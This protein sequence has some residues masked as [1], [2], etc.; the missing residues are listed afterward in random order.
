VVVTTLVDAA[1]VTAA[2][3]AALYR[4]RWQVEVY[5]PQCP[6]SRRLY[7]LAA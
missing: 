4:A 5:Q 1:T 2:D 7:Q 6:S 3:L